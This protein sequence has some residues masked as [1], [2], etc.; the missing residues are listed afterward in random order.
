MRDLPT[1]TDD[2]Y[3]YHSFDVSSHLDAA[4]PL[5]LALDIMDGKVHPCLHQDAVLES[6]I[7]R[8]TEDTQEEVD[9]AILPCRDRRVLQDIWFYN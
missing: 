3:R 9:T 5:Q 2:P 1:Q 6:T 7:D 8:S 4:P